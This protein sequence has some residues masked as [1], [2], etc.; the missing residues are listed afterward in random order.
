M[1][2]HRDVQTG[3]P[4]MDPVERTAKAIRLVVEEQV[5]R[6]L[7]EGRKMN[8]QKLQEWMETRGFQWEE[9][10][11]EQTL[12]QVRDYWRLR[13]RILRMLRVFHPHQVKRLSWGL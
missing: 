5:G 13:C 12:I 8:G 7:L 11:A 1:S 3:E 10:M 9:L 2:K 4:W 6:L